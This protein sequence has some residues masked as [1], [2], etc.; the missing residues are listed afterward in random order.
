M[1]F[2]SSLG[3]YDLTEQGSNQCVSRN[4]IFEELLVRNEWRATGCRLETPG[5]DR[6]RWTCVAVI[7]NRWGGGSSRVSG[8]VSDKWG[9]FVS[10]IWSEKRR[11]SA[12]PLQ[13]PTPDLAFKS[14]FHPPPGNV[15]TFIHRCHV[16]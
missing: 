8:S 14:V 6:G 12:H 4:V 5:A 7:M 15:S 16:S 13:Q 10:D 9:V 1:L 3:T 2:L 11:I